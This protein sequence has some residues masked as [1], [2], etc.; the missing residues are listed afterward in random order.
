MKMTHVS[1]KLQGLRC[2]YRQIQALCRTSKT[3]KVKPTWRRTIRIART[4]DP[5]WQCV[6]VQW[7]AVAVNCCCLALCCLTGYSKPRRCQLRWT[8]TV[9]CR[10]SRPR[11]GRWG[12]VLHV[13]QRRTLTCVHSIIRPPRRMS[14]AEVWPQYVLDEISRR[15]ATSCLTLQW[16]LSVD[17]SW[18]WWWW[19]WRRW[20]WWWWWWC[21]DSRCSTVADA[22][23]AH[24]RVVRSSSLSSSSQRLSSLT[25]MM[26]LATSTCN[27]C[28]HESR[29]PSL[30]VSGR[31]CAINYM[32]FKLFNAAAE[33]STASLNWSFN[34]SLSL[35]LRPPG[36]S[37]MSTNQRQLPALS[38]LIGSEP[39]FSVSTHPNNLDKGVYD[40]RWDI[41]RIFTALHAMQTRSS[42]ENPVCSSVCLSHAWIVTKR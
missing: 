8:V 25:D 30:W 18:R 15:C 29:I 12:R 19:W 7:L 3:D 38:T 39:G 23:I 10:Q 28:H 17:E 6:D 22:D 2:I 13:I 26:H 9:A 1:A 35:H 4:E 32:S 21:R 31:Q 5:R 42:D 36:V 24:C 16:A 14:Y 33:Q 37:R 27:M 40:M 20:W 41:F 11:R 34:N